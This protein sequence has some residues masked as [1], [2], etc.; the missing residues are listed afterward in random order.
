MCLLS[1][2][3]SKSEHKIYFYFFT[4]R[5][6]ISYIKGVSK[7]GVFDN[8][9]VDTFKSI[10]LLIPHEKLITKYNDQV[11][12]VVKKIGI[13]LEANI[14][15][16]ETRNKLLSRLISGKLPVENLNIHF[17]PGAEDGEGDVQKSAHGW[18]S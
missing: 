3:L 15:L 9:I 8:I 5:N 13:L 2:N 14:V 10:P 11:G 4:M 1:E 16:G 17:P 7:S 6:A 12:P 18:L